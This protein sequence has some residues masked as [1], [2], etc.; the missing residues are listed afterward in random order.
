MPATPRFLASYMLA[1]ERG[2]TWIELMFVVA[3]IGILSLMAVPGIQENMLKTQVK[4]ALELATL[5]K[6]GVQDAWTATSE[7]PNNN[8]AA[9]IPPKHKIVGN[10][11]K[12]VS[13]KDGAITLTLGNNASKNLENKK[14]TLRP[15]VVAGEPTVPIAWVCHNVPV[16]NG[17]EPKGA[18]ETDIEPKYLPIEC[19][20]GPAK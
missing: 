7:M 14:V 16:P 17:M 18:N 5:A 11:V 6:K 12:E 10:L 13:V 1:R 4:E 9:G 8:A 3:I 15:A 2:F 19:R 20:G